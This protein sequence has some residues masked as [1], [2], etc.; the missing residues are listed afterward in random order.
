MGALACL[1]CLERRGERESDLDC[2]LRVFKGVG[3]VSR[4]FGRGGCSVRGCASQVGS[5][6][7]KSQ[8]G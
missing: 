5:S 8:G 4:E 3:V 2:D 7:L 1:V 6:R